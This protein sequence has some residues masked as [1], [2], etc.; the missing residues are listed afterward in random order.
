MAAIP[1]MVMIMVMNQPKKFLTLPF[2]LSPMTSG[3]ELIFVMKK[4]MIGATNPF[5][6]AE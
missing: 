4:M 3:F 6:T 1:A 2:L 5:A